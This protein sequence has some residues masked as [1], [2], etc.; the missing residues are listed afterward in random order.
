MISKEAGST[1][2]ITSRLTDITYAAMPRRA[3]GNK[4][5]DALEV[6]ATEARGLPDGLTDAPAFRQRR[7]ARANG[8]SSERWSAFRFAHP[9]G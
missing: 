4:L 7:S 2:S 8:S 3:G 9:P 6:A 1:N 5:V